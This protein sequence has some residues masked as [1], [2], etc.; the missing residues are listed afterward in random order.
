M[1]MILYK[2]AAQTDLDR[3]IRM[4]YMNRN[5]MRDLLVSYIETRAA[6][7]GEALL[8]HRETGK[9]YRIRHNE[10][11]DW[12]MQSEH[13]KQK[14]ALPSIAERLL[15][16]GTLYDYVEFTLEEIKAIRHRNTLGK[17]GW[18]LIGIGVAL[19]AVS[20][21]RIS[22]SVQHWQFLPP[23]ENAFSVI[24]VAINL[25][26][27]IAGGVL[28]GKGKSGQLLGNLRKK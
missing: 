13:T 26:V 20:F 7:T 1:P 14:A 3:M 22:V 11:G 9:Q 4:N 21:W 15:K 24:A 5:E 28:L 12:S 17:I 6:D 10:D 19:L 16:E 18:I 23:G 2:D 8:T 27:L 25:I